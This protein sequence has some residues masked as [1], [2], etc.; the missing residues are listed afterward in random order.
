MREIETRTTASGVLPDSILFVSTC[1]ECRREQA[2]KY[3]RAALR[4]LI[5]RAHPIEA[6]CAMCDGYWS[7]TILERAGLSAEL[8]AS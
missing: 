8:A 7:L 1:P 6:Y 4:R 2:Q 5:G 3:S